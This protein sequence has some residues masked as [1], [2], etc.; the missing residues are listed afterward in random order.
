M[1]VSIAVTLK[2]SALDYTNSVCY[3]SPCNL[4]KLQRFERIQNVASAHIVAYHQP[5]RLASSHLFNLHWL[6]IKRRAN[7]KIATLTYKNLAAG[8]RGYLH[9]FATI[10]TY[11]PVRSVRSQDNLYIPVLSVCDRTPTSDAWR[12]ADTGVTRA[13]SIMAYCE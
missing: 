1:V 3:G 13:V 9:L 10:Y 7:F 11:Q 12:F 6:P 2:Q 8:Q 5:K 4:P